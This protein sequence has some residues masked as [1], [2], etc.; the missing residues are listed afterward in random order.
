[1][2]AEMG[3]P[4]YNKQRIPFRV[5]LAGGRS[6]L[7]NRYDSTNCPICDKPLKDGDIVVCPDCGAPYHRDCI[8]EKGGCIFPELHEQ[9]KEWQPPVREAPP[10]A[11]IICSRC[12]AQNPSQGLFCQICGSQLKEGPIPAPPPFP[13]MRG[14]PLDP[15]DNPFGGVAPEEDIDGIPAKEFA[16]FVSQ[17]TPYFLPLF[18]RLSR[19][20]IHL[21]N[22]GAFLFG[23]GYYIYRKMY[24]LGLILLMIQGM[25]WFPYLYAY[26]QALLTGTVTEA[27]ALEIG[28]ISYLCMFLDLGVRLFTGM[29]AN[30]FYFSHCKRKISQLRAQDL[31]PEAY[32]SALARKGST[33]AKLISIVLVACGLLVLV[34]FLL[35]L[36]SLLTG[37]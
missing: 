5:V 36:P 15:Y 20:R 13:P 34:G 9:G 28:S 6:Y 25:V 18:K 8:R 7:M 29:G 37:A 24:A 4:C 1:M 14:M 3:K 22:W 10:P 23:G 17:N 33:A 19:M 30:N 27:A 12:G 11:G 21:L 26:G 31:D 16:V 32:Q 2:V 35:L